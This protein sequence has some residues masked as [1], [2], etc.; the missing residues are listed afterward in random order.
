[1]YLIQINRHDNNPDGYRCGLIYEIYEL[2]LNELKYLCKILENNTIVEDLDFSLAF[3]PKNGVEIITSMMMINST[4]R[5]L[6]LHDNEYG[7]K[8]YFSLQ[9]N[10]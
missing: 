5:K 2:S 1:M 7:E 10:L 6:N 8:E 3:I 4:I 9:T